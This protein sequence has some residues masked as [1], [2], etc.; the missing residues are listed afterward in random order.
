[1]SIRRRW[2][3]T[4]DAPGCDAAVPLIGDQFDGKFELGL[5]VYEAGWDAAPNKDETYCPE[6]NATREEGDHG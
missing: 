2:V 4:C 6:H 5:Q 1:M 3:A